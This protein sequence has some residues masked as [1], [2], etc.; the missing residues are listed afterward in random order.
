MHGKRLLNTRALCVASPYEPIPALVMVPARRRVVRAINLASFALIFES[1]ALTVALPAL[2]REWRVPFTTLQWVAEASLFATVLLLL[3]AGRLSDAWGTRRVMRVGLLG[4]VAA[5]TAAGLSP[6]AEWLIGARLVQGACA[7]LVIPGTLGLLR[8][9]IDDETERREAMTW[10]SGISLAASG[11]GPIVGGLLVDAGLWRA[12]FVLPVLLSIG[13]WHS[14]RVRHGDGSA[15]AHCDQPTQ[16]KLLPIELLKDPEFLASNLA[17][18]SLYFAVYGLSFA[19]ATSLRPSLA[20]SSMM[21]G[22]YM[23][24]PAIVMLALAAPVAKASADERGWWFALVGGACSAAGL[25]LLA[26]AVS[27]AT[28][29]TLI[30][31]TALVGVGFACALGPLDALMMARPSAGE[32]NAASAIGHMTARLAGFAAIA[33]GGAFILSAAMALAGAA[34]AGLMIVSARGSRRTSAPAADPL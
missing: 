18:G 1:S 27:R 2:A 33:L 11:A 20:S 23:T 24:V 5:A 22:L 3:F 32:S 13:A 8:L 28:P 10:W 15:E 21:T 9:F 12:L 30:A 6:S 4:T 14:L 29:A 25:F 16:R 31:L 26:A 17:S 34:V 19:L 7:A